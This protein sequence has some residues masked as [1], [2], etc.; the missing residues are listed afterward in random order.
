MNDLNRYQELNRKARLYTQLLEE[1]KEV[2]CRSL[3]RLRELNRRFDF[4]E[5]L[6]HELEELESMGTGVALGEPSGMGSA[7]L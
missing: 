1:A 6:I 2:S 4:P 7:M 5:E 3:N